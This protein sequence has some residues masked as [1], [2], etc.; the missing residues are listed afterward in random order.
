M[1]NNPENAGKIIGPCLAGAG[2]RPLRDYLQKEAER[3]HSGKATDG[4]VRHQEGRR[5]L[6]VQLLKW[7]RQYGEQ[8]GG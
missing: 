1:G 2:Q 4:E 5:A 6:A 8:N 3:Y 7:Y